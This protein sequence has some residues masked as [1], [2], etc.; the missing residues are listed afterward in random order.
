MIHVSERGYGSSILE[1]KDIVA[2]AE[3]G[4]LTLPSFGL[5]NETGEDP[6][7]SLT[8]AFRRNTDSIGNICN[9]N[10]RSRRRIEIVQNVTPKQVRSAASRRNPS[11]A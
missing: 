6:T 10:H 11:L 8:R 9:R 5:G 4:V 2:A 3:Q 7:I 1:V